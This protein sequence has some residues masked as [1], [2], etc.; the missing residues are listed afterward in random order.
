MMMPR[1]TGSMPSRLAIGNR[2]GAMIRMMP[3]GSMNMPAIEQQHVDHDQELP[4]GHAPADDRLGDHL[5]DALGGQ[6]VREEQR[7]G[8]DEHQ[9]H[10]HLAGVDEDAWHVLEADV[11]VD[12][13]S[14]EKR[15]HGRHRRGFGR[16]EDA[17]V[18][19]AEDDDDQHQPPERLAPGDDDVAQRGARLLGQVEHARAHVDRHHQQET[20]QD[21]RARR[22]PGTACR[23]TSRSRR[24]RPPSRSTA[25]SGC[26]ACRRCRSRRR[27]SSADSRP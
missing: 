26:P 3:V 17:A 18:D 22:R 21:A 5:R 15:V 11:A 23:P 2:I 19:A 7:V 14:D 20:E 4:S 16:R 10:R 24:R 12:E 25:E 13:D 6:H 9:H 27:R 8:D 1:C